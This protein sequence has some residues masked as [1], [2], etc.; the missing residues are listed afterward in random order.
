MIGHN[1]LVQFATKIYIE[2]PI[3]YG[4]NTILLPCHQLIEWRD[5]VS[6]KEI[7]H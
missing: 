5:M 7:P 2:L 6:L 1:C 4:K 3:W